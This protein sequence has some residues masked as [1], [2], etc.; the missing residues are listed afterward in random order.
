MK[1]QYWRPIKEKFIGQQLVRKEPEEQEIFCSTE[2]NGDPQDSTEEAIQYNSSMDQE[3]EYNS[4]IIN[5][6][7][8]QTSKEDLEAEHLQNFCMQ[9]LFML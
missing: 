7:D 3:M 6:E 2:K 8:S 5:G 1:N 4:A 9:E